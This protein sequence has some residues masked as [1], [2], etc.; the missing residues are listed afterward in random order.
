MKDYYVGMDVHKASI[1]IAV[2]NAAGKVV[3]QSIIETKA[4]TVRD[5]V[6]GLHG[7]VRLTFEEGVHAA[8]LYDLT[9]SLVAEVVVCDPRKN[10]LL[11]SGHKSDRVDAQKLAHLL[12][13]GLLQAVYHGEQGTRSLKELAHSYDSL[14]QD[15]T[16]VMNRLRAMY[17]GRAIECPEQSIYDSAGRAQW[18]AQLD[19]K[20]ARLRAENMYKQLDALAALRDEARAQMVNE[21]A[22]HPASQILQRVPMIGPVRAAQIIATVNTPHRFRTKRQFWAYCGLAVVT[23]ASAEYGFTKGELQ[24]K[25]KK[26]STR[27]LTHN[28]NRRLKEV[29][30]SAA[31]TAGVRGQFKPYYEGLLA[32]GMSPEAARLTLAR[33]I[34]ATTLAVWKKGEAFD[35][36]RITQQAA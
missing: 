1:V 11:L 24:K 6:K 8:W 2:Q 19:D 15:C 7:T 25:A 22:A 12:R 32:K 13:A 3:M 36:Q 18:L 26:N 35:P 5:F 23:K 28:F 27:G 34:A 9:H 10:K 31:V 4:Q 14:V 30:K 21:A 20:G 16:R 33:K 17:R 29:F